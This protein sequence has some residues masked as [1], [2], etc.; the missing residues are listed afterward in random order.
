MLHC[1]HE[2]FYHRTTTLMSVGSKSRQSDDSTCRQ[3][4]FPELL[5]A[6][7]GTAGC[8][9]STP[10]A[11]LTSHTASEEA[12]ATGSGATHLL[13]VHFYGYSQLLQLLEQV[14]Q[15]VP[16]VTV[17]GYICETPQCF[18]CSHPGAMSRP[19]TLSNATDHPLAGSVE[20]CTST[21]G[22]QQEARMP[23]EEHCG[24]LATK[25]SGTVET[26]SPR[27]KWPTPEHGTAADAS[28]AFGRS[29]SLSALPSPSPKKHTPSRSQHL[30]PSSKS[31]EDE[32]TTSKLWKDDVP[33]ATSG[34][35]HD[36]QGSERAAI[37]SGKGPMLKDRLT[38]ARQ[39]YALT[40]KLSGT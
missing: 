31:E 39:A 38:D 6:V 24:W 14:A 4:S 33:H 16:A 3:G 11:Q 5:S 19:P 18:D 8:S 32:C 9:Q 36:E 12:L 7:Q 22:P 20:P 28:A 26:K 13:F 37:R 25:G 29:S 1:Q 15:L 17:F 35:E 30:D 40:R 2:L 10:P 21:T 27:G 34:A 23:F